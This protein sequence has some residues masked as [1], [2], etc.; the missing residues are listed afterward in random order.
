MAQFSTKQFFKKIYAHD[1]LVEL[2]KRHN[3]VALFEI[4]ENTPRKN[5]IALF[6]EFHQSLSP[7]EKMATEEDMG[8]IAHV[9]SKHSTYVLNTIL[10]EH[11]K[12]DVTTIECTSDH[13]L[14]FYHF[15]F[16]SDVFED[17]E[18]SNLENRVDFVY[19][20]ADPIFKK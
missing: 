1:L 8:R 18:L 12:S 15:L 14:V 3:I 5:V 9:T 20:N 2:Y 4:T 11:K 16:T 19:R 6:N 13:D 7:E 10:K 17:L